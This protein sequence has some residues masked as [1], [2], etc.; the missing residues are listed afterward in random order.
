MKTVPFALFALSLAACGAP[1]D[2]ALHAIAPA[3]EAVAEAPAEVVVSPSLALLSAAPVAPDTVR[4]GAALDADGSD[5]LIGTFLVG[6]GV[7]LEQGPFSSV[8]DGGTFAAGLPPEQLEWQTIGAFVD[9]DH[10]GAFNRDVDAVFGGGGYA[11]LVVNADGSLTLPRLGTTESDWLT[12]VIPQLLIAA[13][14]TTVE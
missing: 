2:A 8:V 7:S 11:P 12:D 10:D 1:D 6:C 9:V 13:T 14:T 3:D 5:V 4:V